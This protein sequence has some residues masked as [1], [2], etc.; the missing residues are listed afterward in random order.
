M[1]VSADAFTAVVLELTRML[2]F[3]SVPQ[4]SQ[5]ASA[6]R[7]KLFSEAL[8]AFESVH[9]EGLSPAQDPITKTG[10]SP[11]AEAAPPAEKQQS[12]SALAIGAMSSHWIEMLQ[13]LD[14]YD[15][16]IV[17]IEPRSSREAQ[18]RDTTEL[19]LPPKVVM[20]LEKLGIR[21]LYSHQFQAI[22]ALQRGENVVL[23]TS[24]ASGKSLAF[25][26]PMMTSL[27]N[28]PQSTF[29][30]LFPTKVRIAL[31]CKQSRNDY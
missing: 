12:S 3:E 27:V 28:A 14:I 19:H 25:N 31:A 4:T 8:K 22:D 9:G 5:R 30:Y 23:S 6:Q 13:T 18:Y 7:K 26:I 17:H 1:L 2:T 15:N 20:A 24:T 16:Q 10:A 11:E 29:L 21:Q